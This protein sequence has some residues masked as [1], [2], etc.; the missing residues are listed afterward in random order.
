[1]GSKTKEGI[2]DAFRWD[3][4]EVA[5]KQGEILPLKRVAG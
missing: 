2:G 3:F 4:R 1:M 5:K